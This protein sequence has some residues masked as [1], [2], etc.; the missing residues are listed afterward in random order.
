M[1]TESALLIPVPEAEPVISSWRWQFDPAARHGIPAHV[2]LLYP[3]VPPASID[4][5]VVERL[6]GLFGLARPFAFSLFEL[7]RFGDTVLYLAP[8]PDD[9]FRRL[10][11]ALVDEFPDHPPYRGA[12]DGVIP[13]LTIADG[14]SLAAMEEAQASV[15]HAL[16]VA[17]IAAEA[18]LMVG[19]AEDGAWRVM[20]RF[21][22]G[23]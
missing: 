1:E 13:H 12:F 15:A 16:P 11:T 14:A 20:E 9:P 23:E 8:S 2:T 17:S 5:S 7:R 4:A 22:L 3:F 6:G 10:T 18:W 21:A 19:C